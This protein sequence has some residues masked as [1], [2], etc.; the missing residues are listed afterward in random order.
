ML[1]IIFS[2]LVLSTVYLKSW[3]ELAVIFIL[4][5]FTCSYQKEF[6]YLGPKVD[7]ESDFQVSG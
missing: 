3:N 6:L 4:T 2:S 5:T 7:H 1:K